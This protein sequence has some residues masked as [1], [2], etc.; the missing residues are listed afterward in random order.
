MDDAVG[1]AEK[2]A[3]AYRD[4]AGGTDKAATVTVYNVYGD[5]LVTR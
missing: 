4:Y 3:A 2:V 1:K 5:S